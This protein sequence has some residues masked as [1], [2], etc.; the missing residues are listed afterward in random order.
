M[1]AT[2]STSKRQRETQNSRQTAIRQDRGDYFKCDRCGHLYTR[3][4]NAY[5]RHIP[6]CEARSRR[7]REEA[8][9]TLVE[10]DTPTP[11]PYSP[12][13]GSREV[14]SEVQSEFG[15]E[16]AVNHGAPTS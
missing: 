8:V 5:K 9:R 6:V 16:M 3:Y 4:H 14:G 15:T 10:R 12:A 1:P 11:E 2:R 7:Q 13:S